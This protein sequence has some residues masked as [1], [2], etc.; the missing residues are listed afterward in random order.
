MGW[1]RHREDKKRLRKLAKKVEHTGYPRPVYYDEKKNRY[2]R[3]YQAKGIKPMANYYNRRIRQY[4][5]HI[6]NGGYAKRFKQNAQWN[7]W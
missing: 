4:K 5:G 3:I 7:Y 1:K 6:P 2:I